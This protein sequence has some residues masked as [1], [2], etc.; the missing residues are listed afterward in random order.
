M[1]EG[2]LEEFQW[3][4]DLRDS[5][6]GTKT[7]PKYVRTKFQEKS[8]GKEVCQVKI[9]WFSLNNLTL[10]TNKNDHTPIVW[11]GQSQVRPSQLT[12]LLSQWQG[13]RKPPVLSLVSHVPLEQLSERIT[14][15]FDGNAFSVT[16]KLHIERQ[17]ILGR[18]ATKQNC[19]KNKTN[20]Q[21]NQ[22]AAPCFSLATLA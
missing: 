20:K 6:L 12:G 5:D 14:W 21:T 10:W 1:F 19:F 7:D 4:Q 11:L 22:T 13:Y 15:R 2:S 8:L 17:G 18:T 3:L 9:N 16:D